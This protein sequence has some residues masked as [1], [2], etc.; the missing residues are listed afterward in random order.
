MNK[1][2]LL[3]GSNMGDRHF[4]LEKASVEINREFGKISRHSSVYETAAWGNTN[5]KKFL[6]QVVILSSALPAEEMM[7]RIISME[8]KMGRIRKE[9]WEP[10]IIDI[11]ILFFNDEV[12][13]TPNVIVPH[14]GLHERKFTLKP[15]AE[16]IPGFIHPVLRK[17]IAEL[18]EELNDPLEVTKISN[19]L[20]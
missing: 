9:K 7:K 17:S 16:L 12:I 8:E 6:N 19:H 14:P 13:S 5:Q 15:L 20:A 1:V 10:R 4:N 3:L 18:L 11:D 2:V